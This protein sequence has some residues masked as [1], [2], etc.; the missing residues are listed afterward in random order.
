MRH[1]LPVLLACSVLVACEAPGEAP[2]ATTQGASQAAVAANQPGDAA[3]TCDQISAQVNDM[4]ARIARAS[5]A[6]QAAAKGTTDSITANTSSV[7]PMD[8]IRQARAKTE[9]DQ[10]KARAD[11]LVAL[12]KQKRCYAS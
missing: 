11:S 9:A 8:E 1:A 4:N 10:A 12:G 6:A 3:L 5:A 2:Q 7:S